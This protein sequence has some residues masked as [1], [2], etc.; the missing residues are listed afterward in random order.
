VPTSVSPRQRTKIEVPQVS[1]CR[2]HERFHWPINQVL[3][4]SLGVVATP[5]PVDRNP[6]LVQM[7]LAMPPTPPRADLLVLIE[8][9]GR[10][11]QPPVAAAGA[12][13]ATG[14]APVVERTG[15]VPGQSYG[16]RY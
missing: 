1:H 16:G 13:A 10:A 14:A 15:R 3:L 11:S 2:L 8:H 6:N 12:A 9:K 4:V 5:T 7:A